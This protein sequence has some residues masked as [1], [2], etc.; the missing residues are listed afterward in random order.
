MNVFKSLVLA[1]AFLL[2]GG[3]ALATS[4]STKT[5]SKTATKTETSATVH[6]ET[7]VVTYLGSSDFILS[8]NYEG[9]QAHT[10]FKLDPSTKKEGTL[11]KGSHVLVYFKDINKQRIATEVKLEP[12]K[13]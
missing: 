8:Y 4:A 7:G 12:S 5:D 1:A 2:L 3:V 6:H 10:T 9:K 13:S 11:E